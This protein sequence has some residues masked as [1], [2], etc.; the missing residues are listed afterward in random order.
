MVAPRLHN[1]TLGWPDP[2]MPEALFCSLE[3]QY[4]QLVK[5]NGEDRW[6]FSKRDFDLLDLTPATGP[7]S[8]LLVD[9]LTPYLHAGDGMAGVQRTFEALWQVAARQQPRVF[10]ASVFQTDPDHLRLL[11]GIE[12]V[13]GIR[14]VTLDLGANWD[15]TKGVRAIDVRGANSASAEVLAAAGHFPQWVRN[16]PDRRVPRVLMLGYQT[17]QDGDE[18]VL[19][20]ESWGRVPNLN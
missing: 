8:G 13:P 12:H 6:G 10:R 7:N 20:H 1:G 9:V 17:R 5:W 2:A 14:R 16:A 18:D 11:P 15:P 4:Q 3:E 19:H